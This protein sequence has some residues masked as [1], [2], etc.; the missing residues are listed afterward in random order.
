MFIACT[1]GICKEDDG[2]NYKGLAGEKEERRKFDFDTLGQRQ[3]RKATKG[4][5]G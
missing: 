1:Y 4:K 5:Q 3:S 2:E